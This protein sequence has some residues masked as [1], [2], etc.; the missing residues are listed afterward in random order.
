[1]WF[2]DQQDDFFKGANSI[3]PSS[4]CAEAAAGAAF[5]AYQ[6]GL[7][8]IWDKALEALDGVLAIGAPQHAQ[9]P[10]LA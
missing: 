9:H 1:M 7:V 8:D 10:T 6:A 4:A 3:T 2:A 5:L